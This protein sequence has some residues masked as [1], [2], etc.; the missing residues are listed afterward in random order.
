MDPLQQVVQEIEKRKSFVVT[1]HARP[2]GD[3]V[4]SSLAM[5]QILRGLGKQAE[6]VL[7]DSVP[8]L[9]QPLPYALSVLHTSYVNGRYDAAIILEC[10]SA[11]RSRVEGLENYFL[12]SIDHHASSRP[13]ANVNWIDASACAVGEMV[14]RLALATRIKITPDIAT[15]LY[16]AVLTDTGSF[17][18]SST[19]A[20][21][22]DLARQLVEL[23]A[24][25]AEIAHNVYYSSPIG[26]MRLLGATL[27]T[28][29]HEDGVT[30]MHVSR[31]DMELCGAVD[32]D[33]E[34]LVNYALGI[35]GV[36]VAV[37]FRELANE[38]IRV[39]IRSK[40]AVNVSAFAEK[41]GGGGHDCAAGFSV[42]GPVGAATERVLQELRQRM[43]PSR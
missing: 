37:F 4:G 5:A 29:Q 38:R 12:I 30:W 14:Y 24:Q 42:E 15:C 11:Q 26:K 3:A 33:C 9:Y 10:D 7:A 23:G 2:D 19:N 20:H 1:S 25:P 36:E 22:F 16:A 40:G 18:Y 21:T 32:E 6:V 43:A 34:G 8:V 27:N 39:S 28:L 13:W 31:R 35:A 41:F 17:S